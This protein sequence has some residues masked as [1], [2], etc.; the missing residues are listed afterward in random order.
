M[1]PRFRARPQH[2]RRSGLRAVSS[3]YEPMRGRSLIHGRFMNASLSLGFDLSFDDL[4]SREGLARVDASFLDYLGER[5]GELKG[6]LEAARASPAAVKGDPESELLI[7]LAPI[8]EDFVGRLF[9]VETEL[10]ASRAA[11][12]ELSAVF[13]VKRQFVQRRATRKYSADAQALDGAALRAQLEPLIGGA[14]TEVSFAKAV[15]RWLAD[16]EAN[17]EA[18][19]LA[20]RY[21]AWATL[22]VSGQAAHHRGVLF[23]VPGKVDPLALVPSV[24]DPVAGVP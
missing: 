13:E 10:G 3:L 18:L 19:D 12:A 7:A 11:R 16:E 4:H 24:N 22:S 9:G 21:A 5:D 15:E 14:L 2:R 17:A 6:R 8:L 23:K 20:A 1:P